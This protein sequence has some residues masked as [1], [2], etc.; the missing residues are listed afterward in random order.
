MFCCYFPRIIR[1]RL[2]KKG[3]FPKIIRYRMS[4]KQ[5]LSRIFIHIQSS[6]TKRVSCDNSR[7]KLKYTHVLSLG[8]LHTFCT[9]DILYERSR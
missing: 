9:I 2:S 8:I 7:L 4:L 1:L 3:C 5:I 6:I